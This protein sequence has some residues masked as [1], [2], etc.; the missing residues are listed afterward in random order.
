M[1]AD[2][3]RDDEGGAGRA[4]PAEGDES[5]DALLTGEPPGE[6]APP[7]APERPSRGSAP[8]KPSAHTEKTLGLELGRLFGLNPRLLVDPEPARAPEPPRRPDDT[9]DPD[10]PA[11]TH[12]TDDTDPGS[13][14]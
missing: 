13:T 2:E 12:D 1:P 5:L 3:E 14:S 10:D 6:P 4:D 11:S 9:A 8:L 7:E